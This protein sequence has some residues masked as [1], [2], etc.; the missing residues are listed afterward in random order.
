MALQQVTTAFDFAGIQYRVGDV[1]ED[2]SYVFTA[3]GSKFTAWDGLF[4]SSLA[5]IT[6]V[7]GSTSASGTL[8]LRS[9]SSGTLGTI[10]ML[11]GV[12][13]WG[14][15]ATFT[16]K[17][18]SFFAASNTFTLNFSG[19]SLGGGLTYTGANSGLVSMKP[20]VI[21][22]GATSGSVAYMGF[23]NTPTLK[24]DPAVACNLGVT[25][26]FL[27]IPT[28]TADTQSITWGSTADFFS[29][30]TLSTT[31]GGTLTLNADTVNFEGQITVSD[32][33][34]VGGSTYACFAMVAPSVTGGT[35]TNV[36]GLRIAAH[37]A[38]STTSTGVDVQ[39]LTGAGTNIG[40]KL[41]K[42]S[43]GSVEN[44]SLKIAGTV[45]Y[46]PT[47]KTITATT[48]TIPH[49]AAVITLNNTSGS[50]KTLAPAGNAAIISDG[51]N[52]EQVLVM[53]VG[54]SDVVLTDQGGL[55]GSNLRLG[56]ATRTL[57]TRD[58]IQLQYS[59][60]IGDWCEIAFTNV[61]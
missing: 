27:S 1:V 35:L 30:I 32:S 9:T 16:A 56:A 29:D 58:S 3:F 57:Q 17:P 21:Y 13:A 28:I 49:D 55:A 7:N 11:S 20:T 46:T 36:T 10:N 2:D 5:T 54:T 41:A 40:I 8:T 50:S 45:V 26:G 60:T 31:N 51:I 42:M 22:A 23:S 47:G 37:G 59:S 33:G 34:V 6:Q 14:T 43:G 44:T 52:G 24:N 25:P 19:A 38:G 39:A 15:D 12:L 53:N 18:K 4:T 61:T 48:D